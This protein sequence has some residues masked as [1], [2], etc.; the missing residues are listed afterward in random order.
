M[1]AMKDLKLRLNEIKEQIC[2]RCRYPECVDDPH[3]NFCPLDSLDELFEET[4]RFQK[5]LE[6]YKRLSSSY[7]ATINKLTQALSEYGI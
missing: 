2:D 3:C 1:G 4:Y 5:D 7:E 6:H